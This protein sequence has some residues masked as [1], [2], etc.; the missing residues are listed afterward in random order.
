[1]EFKISAIG[2][3][4]CVM[5]KP[6]S[7]TS[8]ITE[9]SDADSGQRLHEK[10]DCWG[11]RSVFTWSVDAKKG[12]VLYIAVPGLY[13]TFKMLQSIVKQIYFFFIKIE[14]CKQGQCQITLCSVSILKSIHESLTQ[15]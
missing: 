9:C 8:A 12:S 6:R 4:L 11:Q 15:V 14:L 13:C 7:T 2:S 10:P 3:K 5:S 1:M